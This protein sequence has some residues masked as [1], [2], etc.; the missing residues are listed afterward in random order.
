MKNIE[1]QI[2]NTHLGADLTKSIKGQSKSTLIELLNEIGEFSIDEM[3]NSKIIEAVPILNTVYGLV[4]IGSGVHHVFMLRKLGRFIHGVASQKD[5]ESLQQKLE[6]DNHDNDGLYDQVIYVL[7]RFD[8]LQK[9]D[10]LA[11][12]FLAYLRG[13]ICHDRFLLYLYA[14]DNVN[15]SNI[16]ILYRFYRASIPS[17]SEDRIHLACFLNV[18]LISIDFGDPLMNRSFIS[19]F[20]K[21][22]GYAPNDL[23]KEF[24]EILGYL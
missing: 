7:D 24:L 20:A 17:D 11:Q 16:E 23:G 1:N 6:S 18:G 8:H 5:F 10:A 12:I 14:L 9:A 2:K 13:N 22:I 15:I 21:G 3:S 4:K 19:P